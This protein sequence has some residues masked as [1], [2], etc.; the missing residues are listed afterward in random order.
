MNDS[1]G[2][3]IHIGDKVMH[4]VPPCDVKTREGHVA[5][6]GCCHNFGGASVVEEIRGSVVLVRKTGPNHIPFHLGEMLVVL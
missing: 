3:E 1:T 2:R 4:A 5:G 6:T